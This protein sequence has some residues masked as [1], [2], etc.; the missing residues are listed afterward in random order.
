[1]AATNLI[2]EGL[3][4][5]TA[6]TR[7]HLRR[8]DLHFAQCGPRML[9]GRSRPKA[10]TPRMPQGWPWEGESED[11]EV[12]GSPK[13]APKRLSPQWRPHCWLVSGS[14]SRCPMEGYSRTS[15]PSHLALFLPLTSLYPLT[16]HFSAT[17]NKTATQKNENHLGSKG[18]MSAWRLAREQGCEQPS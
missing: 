2:S 1:M 11:Q 3:R 17:I 18:I 7:T 13:P 10:L 9:N 8:S 12:T 4:E 6:K 16:L 15:F 14:P 5:W